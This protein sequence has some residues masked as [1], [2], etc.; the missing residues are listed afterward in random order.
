[1]KAIYLQ[2]LEIVVRRAR[3]PEWVTFEEIFEQEEEYY[4]YRS[5]LSQI[6][7]NLACI[8]PIV[9]QVLF[10]I[11]Q[12]FDVVRQNDIKRLSVS[13]VELPLFLLFH[14]H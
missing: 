5:E 4:F 10:K 3:Y 12:A 6:F 14:L 8:R 1:M 2:I 11:Q 9:D 7:H 13:Q